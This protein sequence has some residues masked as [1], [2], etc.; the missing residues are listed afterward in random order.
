MAFSQQTVNEAWERSGGKC[1]CKRLNCP[2]PGRCSKILREGSRG[3]ETDLGWEANHITS[4]EADGHDGLSNCEIL[5]QPC[6][7]RTKSYGRSL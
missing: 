3:S 4:V 7:K 6:H 5:C 1:E 2:H